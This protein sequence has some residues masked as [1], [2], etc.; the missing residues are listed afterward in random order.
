MLMNDQT[1]RALGLPMDCGIYNP[2][3][4][5]WCVSRTDVIRYDPHAAMALGLLP[6]A[7]DEAAEAWSD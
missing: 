7:D 3:R 6:E 2:I 5:I 4:D 1:R